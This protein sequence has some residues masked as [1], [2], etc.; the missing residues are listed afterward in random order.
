MLEQIRGSIAG[1]AAVYVACCYCCGCY[2][3]LVLGLGLMT[4]GNFDALQ[5]QCQHR[6]Y[7]L[8]GGMCRDACRRIIRPCSRLLSLE[9][10]AK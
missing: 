6:K 2:K 1:G 7:N 9:L 4:A 8:I 5:A 3:V 10:E